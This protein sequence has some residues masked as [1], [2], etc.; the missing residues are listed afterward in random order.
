MADILD[1][2][3]EQA[4]YAP[5]SQA[6]TIAICK[7]LQTE[8]RTVETFVNELQRDL[9]H[10]QDHVQNLKAA[11]GQGNDEVHNI[12]VSLGDANANLSKLQSEVERNVKATMTLQTSDQ[13]NKDKIVQ[14]EEAKKMIDTRLDVMANDLAQQGISNRKINDDIANRVNEEIKVL[15]KS[16]EGTNLMVDQVNK[17]QKQTAQCEKEDRDS[18]RDAYLRIEN[19][20]NE[21][22]KSNAVTNILENRLASTAKGV[23]QNWAKCSELADGAVKLN[24]CYEK[25]RARVVDAEGQMKLVSDA[26]KQT[27]HDLEDSVRQVE[28]NTDKLAQALKLLEEEGSATEEMRHQLNSL[29]Q[30]AESANKRSMQLAQEMKDVAEATQQ[31]RAGLKEQSAVLLP[32]I[33]MDSPEVASSA[34]RHGSLLVTSGSGASS[35]RSRPGLGGSGGTPRSAKWT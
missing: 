25:T 28:R 19:V 2:T 27:Q 22:K 24:E 10:T 32:N 18:L 6:Q 33:H 1:G 11:Q 12:H 31:V 35:A 14:L 34:A 4:G 20:L 5:L 16:V 15:Q 13:S 30:S 21:V 3:S 23:Q 9:Q 29:R 17:D 7:H 8:I 26:G